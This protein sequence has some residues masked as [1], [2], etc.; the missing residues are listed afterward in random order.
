LRLLIDTGLL[1]ASERSLNV[2]VQA[3][4]DAGR[5]LCGAGFGLFVY[6]HLDATGEPC[7]KAA[8][9]G[10][11]PARAAT[12][13]PMVDL[14]QLFAEHRGSHAL[15]VVRLADVDLLPESQRPCIFSGLAPPLRSYL[16]APVRCRS[17]DLVGALL[18][19]HASPNAFTREGEDLIATIASQAAVAID[20]FRLGHNLVHEVAMAD[21]ARTLQRETAG[22][23]RQALEAAQLGTFTWDRIT[24][25]LDLDE[26]AAQLLGVPI[27][28]RITRNALRER[29]MVPEDAPLTALKLEEALESGSNYQAE[30][31]I[32]T[33][34]G[35]K[36]WIAASGIHTYA[37]GRHGS[38]QGGNQIA[39]MVGTVQDITARRT[40]EQT[41][42][43]SEKLA[44]T[45]RLAATIAHEINN[46]LEAIT[47]LI[48]LSRTDPGI[49][50]PVQTLLETADAELAR[51]AQIAQ[52]TLGFYRDTARPVTIDVNELLVGIADLFERKMR[53]KRLTC[54]FDLEPGAC[55][56]A[57]QGE[58]RQVFS[59]L[60]VNAMDASHQS[61]LHIRT[62]VR[63]SFG[64]DSVTVLI[65]D[66]GAGIPSSVRSRLFTPF[67]TSKES[68]GTGL[69]LWV[70]RGI[71]EK[72]GG[73]IA[74]RSR[75]ESPSGTLFRVVLP[76]RPPAPI[77]PSPVQ[78]HLR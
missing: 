66:R 23:L 35:E 24:D 33:P 42:R 20:N 62:R 16:A 65:S 39:G 1:L 60:L 38:T 26:R 27:G 4:L 14:R 57:L 69:G 71:V 10:I 17:L 44:A 63:R 29:I 25:L 45:G 52:Q 50:A 46:P 78:P 12:L 53:S 7:Q 31:R 74:F 37:P 77:F 2:I 28:E 19:G 56:F 49:P 9:S 36:L 55:T 18:F 13:A 51:V 58:M 8:V 61:Q 41:L 47:N 75:T 54:T 5:K 70:T 30:Y 6:V 73:F 40:Q 11:D 76:V 21:G 32:E 68:V 43:Q 59:N 3:A 34:A 48:Y 22:R 72:H 67:V 64:I 15:G